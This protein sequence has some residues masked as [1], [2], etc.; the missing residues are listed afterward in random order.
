MSAPCS[1][2]ALKISTRPFPAVMWTIGV[3]VRVGRNLKSAP[4]AIRARSAP[5]RPKPAARQSGGI[6]KLK[7]AS[8][9]APLSNSKCTISVFPSRAATWRGVHSPFLSLASLHYLQPVIHDFFVVT[10]C[11]GMQCLSYLCSCPHQL[12]C[13]VSV[14]LAAACLRGALSN[15]ADCSDVK[16]SARKSKSSTSAPR[17]AS[18]PSRFAVGSVGSVLWSACCSVGCGRHARVCHS[19]SSTL[20]VPIAQTMT[21]PLRTNITKNAKHPR[22]STVPGLDA[23]PFLPCRRRRQTQHTT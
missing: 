11:G 15:S 22:I 8:L 23:A 19:C 2:I 12:L 5:T 1:I 6:P 10:T 16:T 14:A 21:T 13:E 7:K 9:L 3:L 18:H 17:S 4:A 20:Q